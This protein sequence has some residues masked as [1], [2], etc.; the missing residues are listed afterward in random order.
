MRPYGRMLRTGAIVLAAGLLAA[1]CT[2]IQRVSVDSG[3][4]DPNGCSVCSGTNDPSISADGRYVAFSSRAS[5]LVPGDGNSTDD[6][7]RRDLLTGTTVR[8]SVD[9]G[10][11]DPNGNSNDLSISADGRYV[12]F[13]SAASDLVPGD[14]N[15]AND[16]F[17]RD[18]QVGSTA[19]VSVNVFGGDFR[20]G[21]GQ[22]SISADGRYVAFSAGNGAPNVFRRDLEAGTTTQVSVDT[23]PISFSNQPSISADGRYVAF[24]ALDLVLGGGNGTWDVFRR[25]L[26]AGTT[27]RLSVDAGDGNGGDRLSISGD[28]RYVVFSSFAVLVPGDGNATR[29]VYL[30][31]VAAGTTTRVSVDTGGG[32]PN[33]YSDNPS[34]SDDGRYVAFHSLASNLVSG[35]S[36]GIEDVFVRDRVLGRTILLSRD[37]FHGQANGPS[38][39]PRVSRD[40]RYVAFLSGATNLVPDDANGVPDVFIKYTRVVTVSGIS[41]NTISRGSTKT[42]VITGTGFESGSTLSIPRPTAD[43]GTIMIRRVR[44]VSDTKI[45]ALVSVPADA[46]V[47]DWDILVW[48]PP[49]V[50]GPTRVAA[51][52]C[53]DCLQVVA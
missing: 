32:D 39:M 28:G 50:L 27:T 1:G 42:L 21:S 33:A 2:W 7:F 23:G 36:N 44:V 47:G 53:S 43:G 14:S 22:P 31:D 38:V 29:D 3:G 5:D 16:V 6:I 46:L 10:G 26:E 40:G 15:G 19:R 45:T 12:A 11:G 30:W 18:L 8:V 9:T 48:H 37:L 25:D 41:P 51:G 20:F 17:V 34:I 24:S 52:Q 49:T 4:G 35:D 13:V